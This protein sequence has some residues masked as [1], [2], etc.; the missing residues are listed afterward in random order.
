MNPNKEWINLAAICH[1]PVIIAGADGKLLHANSAAVALIEPEW[2]DKGMHLQDI[3]VEP[4]AGL[5]KTMN[6]DDVNEV[7]ESAEMVLEMK[8]HWGKPFQVKCSGQLS[9]DKTAYF[10]TLQKKAS[11]SLQQDL[12]D[13]FYEYSN[14]AW[15]FFNVTGH[16]EY[17]NKVAQRISLIVS[18]RELM[19][20]MHYKD[21]TFGDSSFSLEALFDSALLGNE[22]NEV[23][24]FSIR[25]RKLVL[26]FN[27]RPVRKGNHLNGVVLTIRDVS[28]EKHLEQLHKE[29]EFALR[30]SEEKYKSLIENAFD[31]IYITRGRHFE[32]VNK[33]F[34]DITGFSA[35]EVTQPGFDFSVTL[36]EKSR[37]IVDER[38]KARQRGEELPSRYTF[39]LQSKSGKITDV[40]I[41]TVALKEDEVVV[42]GI[43][44]DITDQLATKQALEN[45]KSYFRQLF[46]S[47][48]FGI[49]L[50]DEFDKVQDSN[51]A[52]LEMFGFE[53]DKVTNKLIN[54]LI[55]PKD[56]KHEGA[57][58]T[59]KVA[60]GKQFVI[61]TRRQRSDGTMVDVSLI[62]KPIQTTDGRKLVFG[63]YQDISER[64]LIRKA[65]E[66]EK[67]YF[68]N[69][70]ESIPFGIVLLRED[71]EVIDCNDGFVNL[72]QFT[73]AEVLGKGNIGIIFP[74]EF[75][76]EGVDFRKKVANGERVYFE[77]LRQRKDQQKIDVAITARPLH[78][79]DGE[80]YIFAVYQDISKR[81]RAENALK[82][83]ETQLSNL[84][85]NLPGM[86]YRCL[87]DRDYTML[88]VS[89]GSLKVTGYTAE[90]FTR[91]EKPL[92]FNDIILPEYR[93]PIWKKWEKTIKTGEAFEEQYEIFDADGNIRWVWERGRGVYDRNGRLIFLEGYI[94]DITER[95]KTEEALTEERELMQAL[96]DNIPDTIYFKDK[97]SR[98]IRV[99]FS[100]AQVL[101]VKKPEDAVGKSDHDF[102]NKEH[103]DQAMREEQEMIRTGDAVINQHEHILTSRGWRWFTAT[104]VPLYDKSG[105][106][107]GLAG[108]S[109][110]ITELK[111]MEELLRESEQHLRKTNAEKDKLFSVIAHDLRSPFNS[112]MMLTEMFVDE[113]FNI[114]LDEMKR[115]TATLHKSA[116]S[117][118]DLLENLL[119]W[120]R[121]QRGLAVV[122]PKLMPVKQIMQNNLDY[123]NTQI[124]NKKINIDNQIDDTIGIVADKSMLSSVLRNLIS[125][126]VKFTPHGGKITLDAKESEADSVTIVIRDSGIGIPDDILLK[127]FS[128]EIKG[129]KGT[130]GEPS[131]GLGLILV[132]EFVEINN[133]TIRVESKENAGTAFYVTLPATE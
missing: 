34:S 133:G 36:T 17:F 110:D 112:F 20:G 63:I 45:E 47:V 91:N 4:P 1:E 87:L 72:F 78:R 6:A 66:G 84:I 105:N 28:N 111:H 130:D 50:L 68:Q 83:S 99:N 61:E 22:M 100:Q 92:A 131:S 46:E 58:L 62:G 120:S 123:F 11:K 76:E 122:E 132:K 30:K 2:K 16:L 7:D 104:K 102:F 96:M 40:E 107:Y 35:E 74:P 70:F 85:G 67:I 80:L 60:D 124:I 75:V 69:L 97:E 8:N 81:K 82:E 114:S 10:I 125:N 52:F 5:L 89:E 43:M 128:V 9:V 90:Q 118:S 49:V 98:F 18:G 44:R 86:V 54:D 51:H 26:E 55:V 106:I 121:I 48:P 115:L 31:A 38:F 53:Q 13:T 71:G 64:L 41:T 19:N 79:P 33:R 23:G 103:A 15:M 32:Y 129:R 95:K 77:T 127:L 42:M 88:F 109:R 113:S 116:A 126:A 21:Y 56:L 24:T 29:A 101:G 108:V 73:K 57:D 59:N 65:I 94:E 3:F 39:Q 12:H 27:F 93:D 37:H 14:T 117:L 25:Q 119:S